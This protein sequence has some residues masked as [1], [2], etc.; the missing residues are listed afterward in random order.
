M[1]DS[2][3]SDNIDEGWLHYEN[4]AYENAEAN[5]EYLI[6]HFPEKPAGY[7]L[8]GLLFYAY[9]EF[10]NA[11]SS[12]RKSLQLITDSSNNGY[13]NYWLGK[14]YNTEESPFD[15]S[16][17]PRVPNPAYDRHMALC[18]FENAFECENYPEKIVGELIG[19]YG[20][21]YFKINNVLKKAAAQFPNNIVYTIQAADNYVKLNRRDTALKLVTDKNIDLKLPSLFY[22]TGELLEQNEDHAGAADFYLKALEKCEDGVLSESILNYCLAKSLYNNGQQEKALVCFQKSYSIIAD[23]NFENSNYRYNTFWASAFGVI[24]CLGH[25]K[26]Y[27]EIESFISEIPFLQEY[28]EFI[29]FELVFSLDGQYFDT[30]CELYLKNNSILLNQI[31][32]KNSNK[33]LREKTQ[34]LLSILY[35]RE[36]LMEKNLVVLREI[37]FGQSAL[38]DS[39][40]GALAQTYMQCV[41]DRVSKKNDTDSII[42]SLN[43]DLATKDGFK[44]EFY[45]DHLREIIESLYSGKKYQQIVD[46]QKSFTKN[47]LDE[48]EC[49][50]EIAFSYSEIND[51]ENAERC[52]EYYLLKNKNCSAGLNNLANLYENKKEI[53]YMEK[54]IE[55]YNQAIKIGGSEEMY[56]RNLKASKKKLDKLL[57]LKSQSDYLEKSF[58]SAVKLIKSEDYFTLETLYGFLLSI[59]KEEDYTENQIPIQREYFPSLMSTSLSKSEKLRELWISKN[60]IFLT[61][62]TDD[63]NVPIYKINPFLEDEVQRQRAII[64]KNEIPSKWIDGIDGINIVKLEEIQYFSL[65]EKIRKVNKKYKSLVERDF[66]ELVFNYLTGNIKATIVLSGSF[67]ELI[68]TYYLERK[69]NMNIQYT[70]NGRIV[71]KDL[72]NCNLFDLISFIEQNAYFGKEFFHLTNLSRIYRNF[73]HPGLELKNELNKGKSDLCFIST[74]E[75]LKVV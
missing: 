61:D 23:Y 15:F 29:D 19:L 36:G 40:Y 51:N 41:K 68:L 27:S 31:R 45:L 49:W 57:K 26:S 73:I 59:K 52:Y 47:K 35:E 20:K 30:D 14:V 17:A 4:K 48:V 2:R 75:I 67:V 39:G 12:L 66:N 71:N 32:K 11:V 60:Y 3:Y 37:D 70:Y 64:S 69:R 24:S 1:E 34:W 58:R 43:A 16:Q 53:G 44:E 10:E 25:S 55:M 74:M 21:D 13:V 46:L 65:I 6:Q 7:C 33:I 22:K 42:K 38:K 50:F 8:K 9:N 62:Q 63:Y 54:A 5:A 18:C 56:V 72:Y 28:I